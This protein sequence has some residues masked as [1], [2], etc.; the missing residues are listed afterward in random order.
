MKGLY[1]VL[2]L[3]VSNIF[4]TF[5]W[6]GNLK[7]QEMKISTDWPLILII[8]ASWGVALFEYSFM[9][10]ANRIGSDINGGPF[11]LIQLKVIQEAVS[12][13]VFTLIVSLVFKSQTLHWN[14]IVSFLLIILAVYFAFMKTGK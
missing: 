11:N 13:T 3:V 2:L 9:I 7:L 1:T 4:M 5:A 8:L 10:P 12:L 14:H 6:Y